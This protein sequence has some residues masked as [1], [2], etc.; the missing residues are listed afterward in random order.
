MGMTSHRQHFEEVLLITAKYIGIEV[1]HPPK[2]HIQRYPAN[3][4]NQPQLKEMHE[5][6]DTGPDIKKWT[7]DLEGPNRDPAIGMKLRRGH[8]QTPQKLALKIR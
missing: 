6:G 3:F 8:I 1:E 2:S 4:P 5:Y 7:Q